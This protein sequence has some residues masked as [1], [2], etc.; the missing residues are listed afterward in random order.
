MKEKP[1][2]FFDGMCNY[3]N[4]WVNFTIR[5]DKKKKF[6]FS[7]LQS[8]LG[9]EILQKN[10]LRPEDPESFILRDQGKLY[11]KSSAA[12]RI[13]ARLPWYWKWTQVLW[14]FP[15]FIR[16]G[17]YDII[18]KNRYKWWGKRNECMVPAPELKE[19]FL[20]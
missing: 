6:L 20:E 4:R 18:A 14:I 11:F 3:C 9:K 13:A 1:V 17:V 7:T 12:L 8:S 5:Q 2:I 10:D 15:R 16:D 19:R